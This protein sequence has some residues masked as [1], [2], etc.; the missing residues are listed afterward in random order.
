MS[1]AQPY[2]KTHRCRIHADDHALVWRG[3]GDQFPSHPFLFHL[4][5][6]GCLYVEPQPRQLLVYWHPWDWDAAFLRRLQ[7]SE[8]THDA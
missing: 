8:S 1:S 2:H 4:M 7:Q 6:T 3:T 5:Y